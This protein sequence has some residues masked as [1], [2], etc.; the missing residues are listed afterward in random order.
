MFLRNKKTDEGI[1]LEQ[2]YVIRDRAL[3]LID[4]GYID[5]EIR[6]LCGAAQTLID[7]YCPQEEENEV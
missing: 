2:L 5:S 3:R 6:H 1:F 7:A 4:S